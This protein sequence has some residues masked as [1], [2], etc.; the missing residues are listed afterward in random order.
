ML[1]VA[2]I[3]LTLDNIVTEGVLSLCGLI[4]TTLETLVQHWQPC[5]KM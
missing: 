2:Y 5:Y 3:G 4:S 1:S